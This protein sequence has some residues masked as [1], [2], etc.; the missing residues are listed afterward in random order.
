MNEKEKILESWIM[1]EHLSE[2]DIKVKDKSILAFINLEN[3]DF[4]SLL[5]N[6]IEK[7]KFRK[8]QKGGVVVYFDIFPFDVV[9]SILRDVYGLKPTNE[10]IRTGNKFSFALYFDKELN[11]RNDMTFFTESAYV[12]YIKKIPHEN[13][14][15]KFEEDFKIIINQI[16]GDASKNP[17]KFNAAML[18]AMETYKIDV[19]NCRMQILNNLETDA[20]NLH[21]FFI[22][23]LQKAKKICTTNLDAY[24]GGKNTGRINLDSK[25]GSINFNPSV[26]WEILQPRNY[27]VGRFLSKTKYELSL[28]Q[29]VA[30]NLAIGYDN[31]QIR[32][33]NGPPGTGKT[34]L[35]KDIF[36]EL[37]VRQAYDIA[38]LKDKFVKGTERTRY[39][40]NASIG[41]IPSYI[42]ENSIIVASSN[43]GAVQNI[44]NELPLLSEVDEKL[45]EELKDADY[46]YQ[47]SNLKLST[48]WKK[49]DE[50]QPHEHLVTKPNT[51]GE[52]YWGLFSLEGGKADNMTNVLT[53]IKHI[54]DYLENKY[55]PNNKIYSEFKEKYK[56]VEK[57]R[58]KIQTF[59]S[60]YKKYKK[61]CIT[62][63]NIKSSYSIDLEKKEYEL[64]QKL[65]ELNGM[66]E[67]L[68][69]EHRR[70]EKLLNDIVDRKSVTEKDRNSMELCLQLMKEQKPKFFAKRQ[71]K[72]E[73]RKKREDMTSQLFELVRK[74][75]ECEKQEKSLKQEIRE[76]HNKIQ[77]YLGEQ[78]NEKQEFEKWDSS[79]KEEIFQLERRMS[80]YENEQKG[81]TVKVLDMSLDYDALQKSNPWFDETYRIAQ[82]KLFIMSLRVRKQ[83][84]YEN[85]KNIKAATII[86]DKQKEYLEKKE[87]VVAAWNWI[88]MTIPVI[89]S[90][91][92]SFSRM[93]KNLEA[94][95]LGHL[96][97]DEAGQ[98]LPQASVGA[99]FR[100]RHVMVVGDPSQIKPVLTLDSSVLS[101]LRK[102][103]EVTEKYLSDSAST[104][105]L[106]DSVSHYG[107]YKEQN[108]SDDSWIGVPL[109][110]H[111]RCMY[112]MF[113]ISN[114]ISYNGYMVQGEA[115]YGKSE[116]Y[117]I[118]G[119]ADDKYV[120]E[121]G[122]FLLTKIQEMIT[123]NPEI[124]N[125]KEDDIIYVISPFANVA[126]QLSQELKKIGFTRYDENGKP[127]NVGTIHTFQG[128]EALI[129]FLVLGADNQSKGAAS[130]AVSEPNMMN[131]AA[132]RAKEEF[133]V[134]GDKRLYLGLGCD[135]ATNTYRIINEYRKNNHS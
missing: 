121:Q 106:V 132:T 103:F 101:M 80:E 67:K 33:V 42:T 14:F 111:R 99:I 117:D 30:V 128:K 116:W 90:T 88:N 102:H 27:P 84:L 11:L 114:E 4:Y 131:V 8:G 66:I 61:D 16:F 7:K 49:D 58:T 18:R 82:S 74:S 91:F 108:G 12:R 87:V 81:R 3:N 6:E 23:D 69:I 34:T 119:S 68:N 22:G 40:N 48:E 36:A 135:V 63:K 17:D 104:Q 32:S 110:V 52:R 76:I 96:F 2:G 112:P 77:H 79:V 95:T 93:C 54:V 130:W 62:L 5:S 1:V 65:Q 129:V 47:L 133:Y 124:I 78:Q 45:I 85:R 24:L 113:T 115:K 41:E 19:R 100:S 38:E 44:V 109:W 127:T 75:I 86:W 70:L 125:K 46:F 89:S 29:Q 134:I 107:F 98:A 21:S 37:I 9:V 94:E 57:L 122:T 51:E 123:K 56:E 60:E 20:T 43:N 118:T 72:N 53:S 120:K 26:F 25:S 71:V 64:K 126:Y 35:L 31:R 28:M 50:G 15:I 92:A 13:E 59:S 73:Y 97:I 10:E 83:F 39:F 105:T 55:E